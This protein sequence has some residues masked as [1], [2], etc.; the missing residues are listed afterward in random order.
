MVGRAWMLAGIVP[1]P[2][3]KLI[4]C[5]PER[6]KAA[7][8]TSGWTKRSEG[9]DVILQLA[10]SKTNCLLGPMKNI[11]FWLKNCAYD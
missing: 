4:P 7:L 1:S 3:V 9:Y 6:M 2:L 10:D 11:S 8:G 5:T